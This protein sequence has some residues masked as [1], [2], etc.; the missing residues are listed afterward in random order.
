VG[1]SQVPPTAEPAAP[2]ADLWAA[3]SELPPTYPGY[4]A[5]PAEAEYGRFE[6]LP[7]PTPPSPKR[8][9]A[10]AVG[11]SV[12]AVVIVAVAVAAALMA[13]R[14]PDE[15]TAIQ[16]TTEPTAGLGTLVHSHGIT[17]D[18]PEGWRNLPTSPAE[19][20]A[21]AAKLATT[22]PTLSKA[23]SQESTNALLDHFALFAVKAQSDVSSGLELLDVVVGSSGG[24][25]TDALSA[26]TKSELA[27]AHATD[28]KQTPALVGDFPGIKIDY[29]LPINTASGTVVVSAT[30]FSVIHDGRLV[31][32]V[33]N[34][35]GDGVD[36]QAIADSLAFQ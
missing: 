21:M 6:T 32:L 14:S 27:G 2:A 15:H 34:N 1:D 31:E 20:K 10:L 5:P 30:L 3:P 26:V 13:N 11:V 19:L 18:L 8:R 24:V 4:Q 7:E 22:N 16:T 23:M 9:R 36:A 29:R 17:V 35:P 12:G 28:V 25:T 33:V